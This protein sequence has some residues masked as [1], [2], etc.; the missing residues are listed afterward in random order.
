VW[1]PE[2]SE[3]AAGSLRDTFGDDAVAVMRAPY[4]F[5]GEDLA[6]RFTA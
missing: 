5:N 4:P 2:L 6:S 3:T 1:S